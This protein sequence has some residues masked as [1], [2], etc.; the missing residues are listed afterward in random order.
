[1][2]NSLLAIAIVAGLFLIGAAIDQEQNLKIG[3][4]NTMELM[5]AM[6][7]VKAA[8]ESIASLEKVINT[9]LETMASEYEKLYTELQ[10]MPEET[11]QSTLQLKLSELQDLEKRIRKFQ[12]DSQTEVDN[13]KVELYKPIQEKATKA[14]EEVAK[15]NHYNFILESGF[16]SLVYADEAENVMDKVKAKMNLE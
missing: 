15:E 4:I 6:P 14:I 11:P 12:N 16:G 13:K 1:M 8:D 3:Y 2:K 9:Q 5:D 10:S 7:E